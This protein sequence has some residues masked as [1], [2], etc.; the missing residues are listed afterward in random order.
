MA[1]KTK[2]Q[3]PVEPTGLQLPAGFA[4]FMAAQTQKKPSQSLDNFTCIVKNAE[5]RN[6]I[7][8]G[9]RC[10]VVRNIKKPRPDGNGDF[11]L[12]SETLTATEAYALAA[13]LMQG[14]ADLER[15]VKQTSS[16]DR[17]F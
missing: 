2:T 4:A 5:F 17:P 16:D 14:I 10:M 15:P 8:N 12:H 9:E 11:D 1:A 13:R 7:V 6:V 3:T